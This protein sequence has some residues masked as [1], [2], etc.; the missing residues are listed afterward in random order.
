MGVDY[1]AVAGYGKELNTENFNEKGLEL[2]EEH[3]DDLNELAESLDIDYAYVGCGY[4]GTDNPCLLF[5]D[6]L[7]D[8]EGYKKFKQ[9]IVDT[10]IFEDPSP[11]WICELYIC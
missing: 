6:P 8:L 3:G 5:E 1:S 10:G 2:L 4:S 9:K 7:S 11:D